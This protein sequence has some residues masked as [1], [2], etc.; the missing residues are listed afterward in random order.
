MYCNNRQLDTVARWGSDESRLLYT[1][2]A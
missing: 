1:W 2:R